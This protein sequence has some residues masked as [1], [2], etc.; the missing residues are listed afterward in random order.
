LVL[1]LGF[2]SS[3]FAQTSCAPTA[4]STLMTQLSNNAAPGSITPQVIRN[5]ICSTTRGL[6]A[7][8]VAQTVATSP[9]TF[10]ATIPGKVVVMSAKIELSGDGGTT[11][12]TLSLTGGAVPVAAN[13][14]VRVTWTGVGSDNL[15]SV[16]WFP[17]Q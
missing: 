4:N 9:Y 11:W 13:D 16:T 12:T 15:P 8:G 17:G 7:I 3:A 1:G 10:T 2:A 5:A 14:Q 6:A